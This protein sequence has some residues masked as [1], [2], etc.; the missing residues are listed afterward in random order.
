MSE[1]GRFWRAV[2]CWVGL[3]IAL[4]A[5][6]GACAPSKPATLDDVLGNWQVSRVNKGSED[7]P[8][9]TTI[10][11]TITPD[12]V[13]LEAPCDTTVSAAVS[14]VD[15]HLI[16]QDPS[17]TTL[18]CHERLAIDWTHMLL[19]SGPN[20]VDFNDDSFVLKGGDQIGEFTRA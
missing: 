1:I 8:E 10:G 2:S 6:R 12:R 16:V 9:E 13:F 15:G 4:M 18:S 17:Y 14:V 11:V 19:R 20:I 7:F 5:G 3:P